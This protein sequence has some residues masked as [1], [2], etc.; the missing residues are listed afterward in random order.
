MWNVWLE[1][2]I[3]TD[4]KYC[5]CSWCFFFFLFFSLKKNIRSHLRAA[6]IVRQ[7]WNVNSDKII[8]TANGDSPSMVYQLH[9]VKYRLL[10]SIIRL[11]YPPQAQIIIMDNRIITRIHIELIAIVSYVYMLITLALC[12]FIFCLCLWRPNSHR[13]K[14]QNWIQVKTTTKQKQLFFFYRCIYCV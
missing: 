3:Q 1:A 4:Y 13:N 9:S 14:W 12:G 7:K 2:D 8:N 11:F 10:I 5:Q 6:E